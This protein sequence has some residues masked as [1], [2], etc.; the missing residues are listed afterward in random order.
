MPY[1]QGGLSHLM[2]LLLVDSLLISRQSLLSFGVPI[3]VI[4]R[5]DIVLEDIHSK[6]PT[7][8]VISEK[9][10][11]TD[12]RS[13]KY[14]KK[15]DPL[16]L[17]HLALCHACYRPNDNTMEYGDGKNYLCRNRLNEYFDD[18]WVEQ[19]WWADK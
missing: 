12:K 13:T 1:H 6:K 17:Q 19:T 14:A 15:D 16:G 4:Q 18:A 11:T 9:L 8:R 5:A 7:R 2:W 3:E 10:P